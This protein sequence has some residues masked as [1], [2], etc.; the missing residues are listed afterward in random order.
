MRFRKRDLFAVVQ[1]T[2]QHVLFSQ[3]FS[4]KGRNRNTWR[5]G[6]H[7]TQLSDWKAEAEEIQTYISSRP[8]SN[9]HNQIFVALQLSTT[10][11]FGCFH[12][13]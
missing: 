9:R 4:Y 5:L 6:N 1:Y 11:I 8:R 3:V 13:R 7:R 12:A 2:S 10:T